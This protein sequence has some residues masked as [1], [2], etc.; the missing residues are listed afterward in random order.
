[1]AEACLVCRLTKS[2]PF[3]AGTTKVLAENVKFAAGQRPGSVSSGQNM[4]SY[5][6]RFFPGKP[7]VV[8]RGNG[9]RAHFMS[10]STKANA[11]LHRFVGSLVPTR[12][13]SLEIM[14]ELLLVLWRKYDGVQEFQNQL[15]CEQS[16]ES[17]L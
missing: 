4:H 5:I 13:D 14:Q 8:W 7:S 6:R 15:G 17:S 9:H 16:T 3:D 12:E 1:M 11:A 2:T 10:A